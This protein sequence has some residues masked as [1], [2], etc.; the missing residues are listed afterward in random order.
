QIDRPQRH[1]EEFT[2]GLAAPG[3]NVRALV[4]RADEIAAELAAG[5]GDKKALGHGERPAS[6]RRKPRASGDVVGG[7]ARP[8]LAPRARVLDDHFV[9]TSWISFRS[10]SAPRIGPWARNVS[11]CL[12][13]G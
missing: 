11:S 12:P 6:P 1:A 10:I 4:K 2:G 8:W 9:G 3:D 5:A 7:A 13:A